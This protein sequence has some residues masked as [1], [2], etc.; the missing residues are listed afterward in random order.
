MKSIF[1]DLQVVQPFDEIKQEVRF[2]EES[3]GQSII[4][5]GLPNDSIVLKLDVDKSGYKKK[6]PYLKTGAKFIHQGCDYCI[7]I[8][9]LEK[10]VLFELKSRQPKGYMDQFLASEIFLNYCNTLWNNFQCCNQNFEFLRVLIS[11]KHKGQL[12]GNKV[13]KLTKE[14]RTKKQE[15]VLAI[16]LSLKVCKFKN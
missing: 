1:C 13:L 3:T 2:I 11:E 12:T 6:S 10:I 9:S 5:G 16:G 4:I 15:T 7:I 14:D 8:P